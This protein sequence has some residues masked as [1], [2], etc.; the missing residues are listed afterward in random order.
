[1]GSIRQYE[2]NITVATY[3]QH[4]HIQAII[5]TGYASI[6]KSSQTFPYLNGLLQPLQ[7]SYGQFLHLKCKQPPLANSY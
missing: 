5:Y 4:D 3:C 7:K 1:M 2:H 6:T